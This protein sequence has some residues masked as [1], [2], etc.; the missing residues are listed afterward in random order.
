MGINL[1]KL[2]CLFLVA[3]LCFISALSAASNVFLVSVAATTPISSQAQMVVDYLEEKGYDATFVYFGSN[4][5]LTFSTEDCALVI[6][7]TF[8]HVKN[9]QFLPSHEAQF[10]QGNNSL[11]NAYPNAEVFLIGLFED[12]D[13]DGLPDY[14]SQGYYQISGGTYGG[15]VQTAF[16]KDYWVNAHNFVGNN[17]SL[18][19]QTPTPTPQ[20][21]TQPHIVPA[22]ELFCQSSTSYTNFKVDITGR[23]SENNTGIPSAQI[24]LSYSVNAGNSWV[25]LTTSITDGNGDFSEVWTPQVTGHYLLK[26]VYAGSPD[27]AAVNKTVSFAVVPFEEQNVFSLTS[28]ST[29]T[30]LFFNSTS[31]ELSFR[32]SGA[33]GTTGYVSVYMPKT[34][35]SD[36]SALKVYLDEVPVTYTADSQAD[37]ILITFT[38]HHSAHQV[39]IALSNTSTISTNNWETG[40]LIGV[41]IAVV[42]TIAVWQL[43]GRKKIQQT[44]K[45]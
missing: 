21:T 1:R 28:N 18:P 35:I 2:T 12:L 40:L 31:Q 5:T 37:S 26:A 30:S 43:C 42:I 17:S 20:P 38:Y 34:L 29:V 3:A 23:L 27:Y 33:S 24:L 6:M 13:R 19:V 44:R 22:L 7:R 41:V 45:G 25:D 39:T 16:P 36:I 14:G 8:E 9:M 32:V 10:I 15:R 11:A 4:R